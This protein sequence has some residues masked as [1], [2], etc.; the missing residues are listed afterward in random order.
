M[1]CRYI[2]TKAKPDLHYKLEMPTVS[3]SILER[4]PFKNS[5]LNQV[6][7]SIILGSSPASSIQ[8]AILKPTNSSPVLKV[9][10]KTNSF[11][12]AIHMNLQHKFKFC[13]YLQNVL[14]KYT[15]HTYRSLPQHTSHVDFS[16]VNSTIRILFKIKI[17]F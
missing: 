7:I 11:R 9:Q 13:L 1:P 17:S 6:P 3:N 10:N 14:I 4:K 12:T 5:F 16:N 2:E 15:P 8:L